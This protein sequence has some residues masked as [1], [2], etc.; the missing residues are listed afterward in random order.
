MSATGAPV[1]GA[2]LVGAGIAV[3]SISAIISI[4]GQHQSG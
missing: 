3:G 4:I 2:T 1:S